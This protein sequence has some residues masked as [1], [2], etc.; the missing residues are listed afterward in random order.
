MI[1]GLTASELRI[2]QTI[3]DH[4][5]EVL[6]WTASEIAAHAG[7]SDATAVRT[8]RRLGFTG[9]RD[10]R[11]TLAR[12]LGWPSSPAAALGSGKAQPFIQE[13]FTAAAESIATMMNA[14]SASGFSRGV[15]LLASAERIIVVANGPSTVF[16]Q[17]FV[18]AARIAGRSAEFWSDTIMQT[19]IAAQLGRRDVCVSISASGINALTIDVTEAAAAAGAKVLAV[20]GYGLS[21]LT[22]I[23]N[24][25]IVVETF[26]YSS[27]NQAAV[28][29]AGLLLLLRGLVIAVAEKTGTT[30]PVMTEAAGRFIY[31]RPTHPGLEKS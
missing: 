10:L 14:K 24:A 25:S 15:K 31:R 4:P 30:A 17:D 1:G 28:N 12:D 16:A 22:E 23:A 9:L 21:R 13:L 6:N 2:A 29:S 27:V 7:T 8:C 3:L 19:V 26:D 11:L 18:Y 5:N 20:T